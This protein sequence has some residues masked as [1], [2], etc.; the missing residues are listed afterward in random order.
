MTTTTDKQPQKRDWYIVVR[1]WIAILILIPI[2]GYMVYGM[3]RM[4]IEAVQ[5][6]AIP[7]WGM[8]GIW[9]F[10]F[11]FVGLILW[12]VCREVDRELAEKKAQER[13]AAE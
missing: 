5:N 10:T 2:V 6:D 12:H 1:E 3:G 9:M 8:I 7:L 13:D 11:S 4:T